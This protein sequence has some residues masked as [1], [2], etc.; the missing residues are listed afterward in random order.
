MNNAGGTRT[1]TAFDVTD[2]LPWASGVSSWDAA[3]RLTAETFNQDNGTAWTNAYDA[4]NAFPWSWSTTHVDEHG[5]GMSQMTANDD[6]TFALGVHDPDGLQEWADLAIVFD[7]GW[8]IV[9]QGGVRHDGTALTAPAI[10]AVLD[11][12][13]WYSHPI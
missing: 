6:G 13:A 2:S 8:N 9:T 3:N 5:H 11:I 4:A 10:A 7:A 1:V 12:V